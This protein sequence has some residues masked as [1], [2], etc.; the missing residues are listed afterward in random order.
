MEII[1]LFISGLVENIKI[2]F[3][4][5]GNNNS[6]MIAPF[7]FLLIKGVINIFRAIMATT[8]PRRYRID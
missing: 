7:I 2:A 5:I 4:F 1:N 3:S 8:I 6:I